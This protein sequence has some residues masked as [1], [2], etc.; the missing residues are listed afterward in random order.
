MLA[1]II[2]VAAEFSNSRRRSMNVSSMAI[3][4]PLGA[5][6][7]IFFIPL[8]YFLVPESIDWLC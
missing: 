3:G 2:A 5:S 4:Y 7:T 8:V 6:A 1:T